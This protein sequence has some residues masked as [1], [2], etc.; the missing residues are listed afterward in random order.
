MGSIRKFVNHKNNLS[1][2]NN[3]LMPNN[4]SFWLN[5]FLFNF[6]KSILFAFFSDYFINF[7]YKKNRNLN[8]FLNYFYFY[9]FYNNFNLL[10]SFFF[11]KFQKWIILLVNFISLSKSSNLKLLDSNIL[12]YKKFF[13]KKLSY[14]FYF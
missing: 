7:F 6:F 3:F 5:F 11:L 14:K 10:G 2:F 12:F 13:F 8:F 4:S 9:K 1:V